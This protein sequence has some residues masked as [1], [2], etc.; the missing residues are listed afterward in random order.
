MPVLNLQNAT[1]RRGSGWGGGGGGIP[2]GTADYFPYWIPGGLSLT[3]QLKNVAGDLLFTRAGAVTPTFTIQ[4]QTTARTS[5]LVFQNLAD[6]K[7]GNITFAPVSNTLAVN[8]VN[9]YV[10]GSTFVGVVSPSVDLLETTGGSEIQLFNHLLT[11]LG[12]NVTIQ[13]TAAAT[14][15]LVSIINGTTARKCT[16]ALSNSAD[17]RTSSIEFDSPTNKLTLN[18]SAISILA[19]PG[20]AT[21]SGSIVDIVETA[22]GSNIGM[23]SNILTYTNGKIIIT[24]GDLFAASLTIENTVTGLSP[25]LY[26]QNIADASFFNVLCGATGTLLQASSTVAGQIGGNLIFQCNGFDADL[27]VDFSGGHKTGF[28]LDRTDWFFNYNNVTIATV[29]WDSGR[30]EMVIGGDYGNRAPNSLLTLVAKTGI[31][32]AAAHVRTTDAATLGE[33]RVS[34]NAVAKY[35]EMI[36]WG[37][38]VGGFVIGGVSTVNA[39]ALS[40]VDSANLVIY[41]NNPASAAYSPISIGQSAGLSGDRVLLSFDASGNIIFNAS[42]PA[43]FGDVAVDGTHRLITSAGELNIEKRVSGS[44]VSDVGTYWGN[45]GGSYYTLTATLALLAFGTTSP[46]ITIDRPGTYLI[47]V[48][49]QIAPN[50]SAVWAAPFAA[51]FGIKR[52]NNG[53]A[54]LSFQ[55]YNYAAG[56][57]AGAP[58][59]YGEITYSAIYTTT[60]ATDVIEL[61]GHVSALPAGGTMEAVAASIIAIRLR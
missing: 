36:S 52:T 53:P 54:Y 14:D 17:A 61:W 3:S 46:T 30:G 59:L 50:G 32:Y 51:E 13:R 28:H 42:F 18:G 48:F 4:A 26:L 2:I 5:V 60:A 44:Y 6:A 15:L 57:F 55:T 34:S 1:S 12:G 31:T 16:I 43:Y 20:I 56:T 49:A 10:N 45:S 38:G 40:A 19:A 25:A 9:T 27:S 21:V 11:Y 24:R 22:G 37:S 23:T 35:I 39:F 7:I 41:T 8:A 33:S 58:F 29:F 47:S